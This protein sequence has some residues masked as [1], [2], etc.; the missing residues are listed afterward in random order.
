M[1]T[2]KLCY[3]PYSFLHRILISIKI[4]KDR[5]MI[6]KGLKIQHTCA[7]IICREKKNFLCMNNG[8][9]NNPPHGCGNFLC[10][11]VLSWHRSKILIDSALL[12]HP[13]T[14]PSCC[15]STLASNR[16]MMEIILSVALALQLK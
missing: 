12:R 11:I 14:S 5:T 1:T 2:Y 13:I 16:T 15:R 7:I 6:S 9:R 8:R 10:R 3:E 4:G